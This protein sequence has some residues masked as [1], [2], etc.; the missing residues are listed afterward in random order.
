M[1]I[2]QTLG[3]FGRSVGQDVF[4]DGLLGGPSGPDPNRQCID[5]DRVSDAEFAAMPAPSSVPTLLWTFSGPTERRE[6]LREAQQTEMGV[7]AAQPQTS[8]EPRLGNLSMTYETSHRPGQ[9]AQAAATVSSGRLNGRPDPGGRSYGAYQLT[10]TAT[11]GRQ[12]QAFLANEGAR[13]AD[14]FQG[15]DPTAAGAFGETWR[16]IAQ[17]EPDA[18]FQAQHDYIQRTHYDRVAENVEARTGL[19]V[20][21]RSPAVRDVVWSMSVQHGRAATLVRDAVRSLEGRVAPNDSGYDRALV[22]ALYDRR[23]AYARQQGFADLIQSRYVPE[24]RDA[25]R[26][27]DG[28]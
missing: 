12:V 9:E 6:L 27:L 20:N 3:A 2:A 17:E 14:R 7:A 4:A 18:F 13:W 10:S 8:G 28:R 24:R 25:L 21:A 5:V 23:E 19:D 16:A 26:M 11:G 22:N 1:N 15:M